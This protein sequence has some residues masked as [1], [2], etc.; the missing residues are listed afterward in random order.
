MIY[1]KNYEVIYDNDVTVIQATIND[2]KLFFKIPSYH[3]IQPLGDPFL[4]AAF[5]PAMLTG[6]PVAIEKHIKISCRLLTGIKKLQEIFKCWY[7]DLKKFDVV[8]DD[9]IESHPASE[10]IASFF[11]GGV[12]GLYT[13]IKNKGEIDYLV[14]INGFDFEMPPDVFEKGMERV[15]KNAY[16]LDKKVIPVETNF[17][18]FMK[19][20]NIDR[21]MNHGSCLASIGQLLGFSKVYIPAT[22]S[23]NHLHPWGSHPLTDRLWSTEA[24]EFVHSGAES[25]RTEKVVSLLTE[26][27]ALIDNLIVCWEY[28]DSNCGKCP[29]CERTMTAL[30]ILGVES[31]SF[32]NEININ[33]IKKIWIGGKGALSYCNENIKLA[34]EY[35]KK[36]IVKALKQAV[37]RYRLRTFK[38]YALDCFY[39]K[40]A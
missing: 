14:Y 23:Y 16:L 35:G 3:K 26:D 24:T 28:P 27:K 20:N 19:M 32:P 8:C 21:P 10:K 40:G 34:E 11:S 12:D 7:P 22:Y 33:A 4:T 6:G 2:F 13:A 1:I 31:S 5:F 37:V 25:M 9:T 38:D 18:S 39:K 30:K 29:K 36:D 17:Y 15:K